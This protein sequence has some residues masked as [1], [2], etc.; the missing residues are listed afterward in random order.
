VLEDFSVTNAFE[1]VAE[2]RKPFYALNMANILNNESIIS[3][4]KQDEE[5]LEFIA[6]DAEILIVDDNSINLTVSEG[7]L[8]PLQMNIDT[9]LSGKEAIDMISQK[10]YDIIFMDHMMPELDGVETT[11]IIRRLHPSYDDIPIIALTANAMDGS[12]D[13]FLSEG[14]N[15]FVAKP[16]E[17]KIIISMIKKWLPQNKIQKLYNQPM[18]KKKD[19]IAISDFQ[20]G[21]LDTKTAINLLGSEKLY[22]SILKDYCKAVEGKCIKIKELIKRYRWKEYTI[23]VHAI[24]SASR[25]VGAMKLGDMAEK[26][27]SAGNNKDVVYIFSHNDEMLDK[28]MEYKTIITDFFTHSGDGVEKEEKTELTIMDNNTLSDFFVEMK[29]AV[30]ELDMDQM[31]RIISDM[32]QYRYSKDGQ[33]LFERLKEAVEQVDVDKCEEIMEEWLKL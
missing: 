2:I 4:I 10:R 7:L 26:L 28:Y 31:D 21:D 5:L 13:L 6:P 8:K 19:T 11:R 33:K 16:I 30:D 23:E 12:K 17:L 15:D 32:N 14:M 1:N 3:D 9:A 22:L 24:K 18:A 20:I 29:N 27:E 25:Q